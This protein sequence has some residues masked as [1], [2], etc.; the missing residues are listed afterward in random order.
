M[1][2]RLKAADDLFALDI[3]AHEAYNNI[4]AHKLLKHVW[5][6]EI[7]EYRWI[8]RP[9]LIKDNKFLASDTRDIDLLSD[10]EIV[11]RH[12]NTWT[13]NPKF[14]PGDVL[15]DGAGRFYLVQSE[16]TIWHL[17]SGTNASL[18]YWVTQGR[19]LT[20]KT[21]AGGG[22]FSAHFKSA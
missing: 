17:E 12:G 4:Y 1:L 15:Q 21:T 18:T 10:A 16:S 9:G 22:K 6:D 11:A 19:T 14:A 7:S 2:N 3:V 13:A 8:G 5:I 20:I